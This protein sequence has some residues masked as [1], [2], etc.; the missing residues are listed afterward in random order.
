MTID[1]SLPNGTA[2]DMGIPD[3]VSKMIGEDASAKRFYGVGT[4]NYLFSC[5]I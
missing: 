3:N 4:V 1:R 5:N 2:N